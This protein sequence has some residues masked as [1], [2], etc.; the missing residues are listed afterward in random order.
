MNAIQQ[1]IVGIFSADR[2]QE[3]TRPGYDS[4]GCS[5]VEEV[6]PYIDS[7]FRTRPAAQI[8]GVM[9][10]FPRRCGGVLYRLAIGER[11]W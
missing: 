11:V 4:Y 7:H 8:I 10:S 5:L 2:M 6:K 9:R 1:M 3:Y